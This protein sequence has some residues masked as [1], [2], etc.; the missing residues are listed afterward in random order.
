MYIYPNIQLNT[1]RTCKWL[2][3]SNL[4][5]ICETFNER[6]A[7]KYGKNISSL[8]NVMCTSKVFNHWFRSF[9]GSISTF[10]VFQQIE[11]WWNRCHLLF[12]YAWIFI[13]AFFWNFIF[14]FGSIIKKIPT[15]FFQVD[16]NDFSEWRKWF[17]FQ[18]VDQCFLISKL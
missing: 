11:I 17:F 14:I 4:H 10:H 1:L 3:I 15:L 2:R 6:V 13:L 16:V 8:I 18:N 12:T 5:L 7:A 9:F